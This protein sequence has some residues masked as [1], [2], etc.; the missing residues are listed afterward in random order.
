M[1]FDGYSSRDNE[2]FWFFEVHWDNPAPVWY[3]PWFDLVNKRTVNILMKKSQ[4]LDPNHYPH[5]NQYLFERQKHVLNP[6]D[7]NK[8]E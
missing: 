4:R 3:T 8:N 7:E 6:I 1:S 2:N 5:E